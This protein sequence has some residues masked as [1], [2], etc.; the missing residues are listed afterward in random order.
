MHALLLVWIGRKQFPRKTASTNCNK[1]RLC[2]AALLLLITE[3]V[4]KNYTQQKDALW[5]VM[6]SI[7]IDGLPALQ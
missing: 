3:G 4:P 7:T 6:Q 2:I 5:T 1:G